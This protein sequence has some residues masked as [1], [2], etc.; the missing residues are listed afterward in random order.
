MKHD[1]L[2]KESEI[3]TKD[4]DNGDICTIYKIHF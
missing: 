3:E 4:D 2:Q 1:Q